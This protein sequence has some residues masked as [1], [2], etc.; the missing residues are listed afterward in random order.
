LEAARQKYG[1][2]DYRDATG[3]MRDVLVASVNES[4]EKNSLGWKCR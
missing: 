4:Y 2:R 3:V 1:S